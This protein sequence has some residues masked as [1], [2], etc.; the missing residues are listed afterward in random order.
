MY[1]LA[2]AFPVLRRFRIPF[3]RDQ[4]MLLM[5][6]LNLLLLGLDHYLAHDLDGTI[7]LYEWIP[8]IF[9]PSAGVLLL[10]AGAV[11]LKR[12]PMANLLATLIFF[13]CIATAALGSYFHLR[14]ALPLYGPIQDLVSLDILVW[15]PP[16]LGPLTFAL[17]AFLGLSAAWEERPLESG[18][19]TLVGGRKL[20]MPYSK[21]RAYFFLTAVFILATLI[22]SV[23]DHARTGFINPWLWLPTS[24][25]VFATAAAWSMGALKRLEKA[26]LYVYI[27]AM[28]LMIFTGLIGAWLHVNQDLVSQ[29]TIVAERFLRGAPIMAPLLFANMGVIGLVVLLEER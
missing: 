12:R 13:A 6:A 21:T 8:I 27:A 28:L 20:R 29:G 10:I 26:D 24:V 9:G 14:Y 19:L 22:S 5:A 23:L 2:E 16:L 1:Y 17:I 7:K 4:I 18:V 25:G 3:S 11:A 15:G